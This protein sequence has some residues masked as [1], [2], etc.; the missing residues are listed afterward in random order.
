LDFLIY[1]QQIINCILDW[2][3]IKL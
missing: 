3:V 1:Y 2:F